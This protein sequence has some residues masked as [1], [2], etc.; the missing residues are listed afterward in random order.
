ML[1]FIWILEFHE[2]QPVDTHSRRL[3]CSFDMSPSF[4]GH[5]LALWY[6][7]MLQAHHHLFRNIGLNLI[8]SERNLAVLEENGIYKP[9]SWDQV[10]YWCWAFVPMRN[11][12]QTEQGSVFMY[13][14]L[15]IYI[16]IC[17][18]KSIQHLLAIYCNP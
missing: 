11:F 17:I 16:Y 3:L 6:N 13:V 5:F 12:P 10:A 2:I 15:H 4:L 7:K 1:S 8:I 18:S 14:C 9:C